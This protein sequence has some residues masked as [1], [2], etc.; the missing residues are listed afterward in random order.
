M[1]GSYFKNVRH[2]LEHKAKGLIEIIDPL[3]YKESE[4]E[5]ARSKKHHGILTKFSSELKFIKNGLDFIEDVKNNYGLNEVVKLHREER[6]PHTDK[7]ET[8]HISELDM[9][10]INVENDVLSIKISGGKLEKQLKARES[11][12]IEIER[13]ETIDGDA[14]PVLNTEN[15]TISGRELLLESVLKTQEGQFEI[16]DEAVHIADQVTIN[17][18]SENFI[19]IPLSLI[20]TPSDV[21]Y[22]PILPFS[23]NNLNNSGEASSM[24]IINNEATKQF[25]TNI[26][27]DYVFQS[28]MTASSGFNGANLN[29]WPDILHR[30]SIGF[31]KYSGGTDY[32]FEEYIPIHYV[33]KTEKSF[34]TTVNVSRQDFVTLEEGE[35]LALVFKHE[36]TL[37]DST[38]FQYYRYIDQNTLVKNLN[39]S[40]RIS[41][42]SEFESTETKTILLKN[43]GDRICNI[44]TGHSNIFKSTALTQGEFANV[45][46][47]CGHWLRGFD[48]LPVHEDNK[49]KPFATSLKDFTQTLKSVFNISLGI[50]NVDGFEKI[51]AEN[52]NYFYNPNIAIRLGKVSNIKRSIAK[53]YL[54]SGMEIGYEKGGEYEDVLGLDEPNGKANYITN[55]TALKNVYKELS[56]YRADVYGEEIQRRKQK[57]DNPTEDAKFDT[58]IF[59]KDL[60][61]VSG[62][63]VERTWQDDFTQAPTGIFSPDTAKN[64][65]LSPARNLRRHGSYIGIAFEHYQDKYLKFGSSTAN[66]GMSTQLI[67]ESSPLVENGNILNQ[68][69]GQRRFDPEYIE[70]NHL[71]DFETIR[72]L[73]QTSNFDGDI[74]PN[75]YCKVQFINEKNE[76][77]YGY[78]I[79]IKTS[80][81]GK[82][83]LLKV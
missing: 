71:V 41:E 81:E 55:F 22:E 12:K 31:I 15:L 3:N 13:I 7:W 48:A 11:E 42:K 40:I 63:L 44:I 10:T 58:D 50:E 61:R 73:K 78:I 25:E 36:L 57:S 54:Y 77:E 51:V 66:S 27:G 72:K 32:A 9:T 8:V 52:M 29:D 5:F 76:Y 18:P 6:H 14:I 39:L 20:Q 64:L 19:L 38:P 30:C 67:G 47:Y 26:E 65:R 59:I 16:T 35:S 69:L 80:A 24:L 62:Q 79:S 82:W 74:I 28:I 49:Y 4:E 2:I 83:K 45:G 43:L 56:K 70:F 17:T 1:N 68:N 60:K 46:A 37:S 53:E 23:F 21:V 34:S 33:D 75:M